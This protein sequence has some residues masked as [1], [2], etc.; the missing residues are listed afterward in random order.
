[1]ANFQ[2]TFDDLASFSLANNDNYLGKTLTLFNSEYI[3]YIYIGLAI[4]IIIIVVLMYKFYYVKRQV[5]D[6]YT[7]AIN[8][9]SIDKS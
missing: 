7:N 4:L 5:N 2:D 8:S 1:M 6:E 9:H 3:N